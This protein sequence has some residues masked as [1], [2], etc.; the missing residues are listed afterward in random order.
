M[1]ICFRVERHEREVAG[2]PPCPEQHEQAREQPG[3]V[4][5]P[6]ADPLRL[7]GRGRKHGRGRFGHRER[8]DRRDDRESGSHD[9][10]RVVADGVEDRLTDGWPECQPDVQRKRG[11]VERLPAPARRRKVARCGEQGHEEERLG[12]TEHRPGQDEQGQRIDDEVQAEG[13]D[14]Q[15]RSEHEHRS[16][17]VAVRAPADDR[18]EEQRTDGKGADRNAHPDR[19][20][21]ERAFG[22]LRGDGQHRAAGSEEG[23]ARRDEDDERAR[24]QPVAGCPGHLGSNPRDSSNR[25]AAA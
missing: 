4:E 25:S 6:N 5:Q 9:P 8:Q 12:R 16:P 3:R 22:E 1:P 17:A 15:Q 13:G 24:D 14:G 23:E 20:G 7:A 10:H 18:P 11:E 2:H 21:V 19:V